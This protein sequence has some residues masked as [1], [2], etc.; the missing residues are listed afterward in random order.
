MAG[1]GRFLLNISKYFDKLSR[2]RT[3]IISDFTL[4]FGCFRIHMFSLNELEII[5][6]DKNMT[7]RK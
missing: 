7:G 3:V 4:A 5:C 2:I 6:F 1:E